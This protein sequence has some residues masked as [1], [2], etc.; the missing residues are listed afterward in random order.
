MPNSNGSDEDFSALPHQ[1][2]VKGNEPIFP[3]RSV[4][5]E[6]FSAL[7]FLQ[8]VKVNEPI[9]LPV[10]SRSTLSQILV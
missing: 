4:I 5:D 6:D 3:H 9:V 7:P 8:G 10:L 2:G 1:Q